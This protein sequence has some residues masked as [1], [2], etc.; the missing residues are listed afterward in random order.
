MH[1]TNV[2]G[3]SCSYLRALNRLGV[4]IICMGMTASCVSCKR[5]HR[6]VTYRGVVV[7]GTTGNPLSGV[8]VSGTY[9]KKRK[10][11]PFDPGNAGWFMY[12]GEHKFTRTNGEGQF[13]LSLRTWKPSLLLIKR[14]YEHR[15]INL[16]DHPPDQKLRIELKRKT[17]D[18][19]QQPATEDN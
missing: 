9:A 12:F 13:K 11:A 2:N 14:G 15:H 8:G 5:N 16:V 4:V 7:D 10:F 19:K 18:A 3:T 6:M 1:T 17:E